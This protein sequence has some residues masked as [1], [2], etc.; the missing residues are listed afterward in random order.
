MGQNA[1][2]LE[3][4]VIYRLRGKGI[5]MRLAMCDDDNSLIQALKPVVYQYANNRHFEVVIDEFNCG[6]D[7]LKSGSSY[8]MVLL[9]YQMG[10]LDGLS[11]AKKLRDKNINCAI[12]FITN[13]PHFVYEA[14][15]VNAFRFYEKPFEPSKLC[16]ALD[17]YFKMYGNDYSLLLQHNR[18]SILVNTKDIIYLEAVNKHCMV[19]L[20]EESIYCA[21]TM[22]AIGRLMPK[23][24]FFKVHRAFTVNFN[25]V[26]RYNNKEIFLKR[27][28]KV[29]ISRTYFTAFRRAYME[30]SDLK[31]PKRRENRR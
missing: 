27:G 17:D 1:V 11:A 30:Y 5:C 3:R 2:I 4:T 14:F 9:D 31:N 18:E 23:G 28:G 6:E 8:D 16:S 26:S 24:H 15:E 25:Y 13:Y 7:L 21:K 12:I 19:H 20:R 10:R 29:F 22:A